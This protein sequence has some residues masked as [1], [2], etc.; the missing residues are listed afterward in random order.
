MT[1]K[2]LGVAEEDCPADL[3]GAF[4][5]TDEE[6]REIG[7][8]GILLEKHFGL[9]QDVEWAIERDLEL[10][11]SIIPLQTRAEVIAQKKSPVDQ[12]VD[13]MLNLYSKR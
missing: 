4:C 11:K 1:C 9:P 13:L 10:P 7:K 5:L 6:A 3:S 12:V 8:L 2:E